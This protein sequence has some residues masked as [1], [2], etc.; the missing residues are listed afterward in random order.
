MPEKVPSGFRFSQCERSIPHSNQR[1]QPPAPLILP[2]ILWC[3]ELIDWIA[4]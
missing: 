2:I 3:I 1:D 4:M